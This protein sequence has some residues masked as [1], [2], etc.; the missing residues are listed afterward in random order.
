MYVY[1][2]KDIGSRFASIDVRTRYASMD[3][4][5]RCVGIDV[6]YQTENLIV[7]I[8]DIEISHI[9]KII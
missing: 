9:N 6:Y 7:Q 3:V 1:Y 5:S 8:V 4:S 2:S